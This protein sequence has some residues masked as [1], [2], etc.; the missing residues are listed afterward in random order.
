MLYRINHG[1]V[2]FNSE[3]ILEDINIE[4]KDGEKIA[5]VGNNGCGKTTLLNLIAN[6]IELSKRDSDEEIYIE[7]YGKIKIGYLKQI[8]GDIIE[9]TLEEEV[10]SA[11]QPMIDMERKMDELVSRMNGDYSEDTIMQY[12]ALQEEFF[13]RG[14]YDYAKDLEII[15]SKLGFSKTDYSKKISEFSGGE[16]TRISLAKVILEKPDILLL[17]EPTNHLDHEMIEWLEN[18][19]NHYEKAVVIVSHDRMFLD[20]VGTKIY[21]IEYK[22]AVAYSGNYS[23]FVQQKKKNY[24]LQMKKYLDQQKQ[25]ERLKETAERFKHIPSKSAMA[26]SKLKYIERV[27]KIER[28]RKADMRTF[29]AVLEPRKNSAQEVFRA[30]RLKTGYPPHFFEVSFSLERGQKLAVMGKNGIGK[31]TLLKTMNGS[32]EPVSGI[33]KWGDNVEIGYFDQ[34]TAEY[35]SE[36][37]VLSDFWSTFPNL[38]QNEVRSFLGAFLFRGDDV[39]KKVSSLSGGE[40]SRLSFAKIF[41]KRPNVLLLDEPTNHMD[42]LGKETLEDIFEQYKGTIV[43]VTHDRYFVNKIADSILF[44]SE[45]GVKY[46]KGGTAADSHPAIYSRKPIYDR[47]EEYEKSIRT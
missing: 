23:S 31:S 36:Q 14:G 21:E 24:E 13:R 34:H 22:T 28:P 25:I 30:D 12:T 43:F 39:Y 15:L 17:D 41:M 10:R 11:Y 27:E 26:R 16:R 32:L 40:R 46:L 5:I 1:I 38:P 20:R 8:A 35:T 29:N 6:E 42:L 9:H 37:T 18:Y 45:S 2:K 7:K 3:T 44:F 33:F 47:L 19:L 4:I